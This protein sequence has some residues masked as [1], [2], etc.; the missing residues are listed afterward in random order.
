MRTKIGCK[1]LT[2]SYVQISPQKGHR[3]DAKS[4][5]FH[6]NLSIKDYIQHQNVLRPKWT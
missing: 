6:P 4:Y 3:G 5:S 2:K 1:K